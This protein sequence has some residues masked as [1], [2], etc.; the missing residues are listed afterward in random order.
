M[1]SSTSAE[2]K[3][4]RI[5]LVAERRLVGQ[6]VEAALRARELDPVLFAW[7]RHGAL[8]V[9]RA[10]LDRSAARVG[11]I[12]CALDSPDLLHDVEVVVGRGPVPWL[13]LTDSREGPR[14]G[15][16]L[17]AG[18]TAVLP[19]STTTAGL[20]LAIRETRAGR[21]SMNKMARAR[22]IRQ[23]HEVAQEQ[24]V[25]IRRMEQLTRREF[26]ILGHLYDGWSVSRISAAAG[27][28]ESTV[29]S[30]VKSL[31]RKL[32]V[33]SQLAAV[34]AYRRSLEVFPRYR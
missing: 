12:L 5:A 15:A 32:G 4:D 31:R 9:F 1:F 23:W 34:A 7:P 24:H 17:E 27:V 11:V 10:G 28:S 30:Q 22:A 16:V 8:G 2:R 14:W 19:T 29:R 6:A 13:V 25:L 26:E 3:D 33:H 21:P 18:A 20:V